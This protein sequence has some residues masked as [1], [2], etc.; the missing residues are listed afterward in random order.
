M[1]QPGDDG[2]HIHFQLDEDIGDLHRMGQVGLAG[3]TH[4]SLVHLGAEDV[5]LAHGI[6]VGIAVEGADF[7]ENVVETNHGD[8]TR[9]GR[10]KGIR[11]NHP[12]DHVEPMGKIRADI[13][14]N[15]QTPLRGFRPVQ[16][17]LGGW[18]GRNGI[19]ALS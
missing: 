8:S 17:A 16:W 3:K 7:F 2:R 18:L 19:T 13:D 10:R 1:Q 14:G 15:N 11:S 9:V 6:E 4:L 12:G 5:G